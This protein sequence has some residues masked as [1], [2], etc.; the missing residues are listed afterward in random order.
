MVCQ[1]LIAFSRACAKLQGVRTALLDLDKATLEAVG[2]WHYQ[3]GPC[4]GVPVPHE[5]VIDA[6]FQPTDSSCFVRL[7]SQ[8]TTR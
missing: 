7:R 2:R 4:D 1:T 5:I 8:Y 6:E 3:S